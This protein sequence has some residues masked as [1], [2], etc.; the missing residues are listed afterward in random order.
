MADAKRFAAAGR[1]DVEG[2]SD[3]RGG[4]CRGTLD[5]GS[6][7]GDTNR[8]GRNA[9][10]IVA[11]DGS[12]GGRQFAASARRTKAGGRSAGSSERSFATARDKRARIAGELAGRASAC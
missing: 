6:D 9:N 10:R 12:A 2:R 5:T 11:H 8:A 7:A 1:D 3:E 4:A